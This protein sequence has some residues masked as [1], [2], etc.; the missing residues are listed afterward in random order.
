MYLYRPFAMDKWVK[1]RMI[2]IISLWELQSLWKTESQQILFNLTI[3]QQK[4]KLKCYSR[5]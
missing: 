5:F 2:P 1:L 3:Y 4:Q